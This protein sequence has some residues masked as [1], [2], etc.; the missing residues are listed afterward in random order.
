MQ[1]NRIHESAI[2]FEKF[3]ATFAESRWNLLMCR[4]RNIK[5]D[6]LNTSDFARSL[7]VCR[8]TSLVGEHG[9]QPTIAGIEVEMVLLGLAQVRL[10]E[11]EGHAKQAIPEVHGNLARGA[12]Q[13]DVVHSLNL[14]ALHWQWAEDDTNI[15]AA[16]C[17]ISCKD[18]SRATRCGACEA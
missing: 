15:D 3:D 4:T 12:D 13:R 7:T 11:E 1:V 17:R 14:K 16:I 5:R 9:E 10:F 8:L 18:E 6:V 2:T